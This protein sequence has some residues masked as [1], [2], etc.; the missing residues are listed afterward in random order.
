MEQSQE[1]LA[2]L[3]GWKDRLSEALCLALLEARGMQSVQ[4]H[5]QSPAAAGKMFHREGGGFVTAQTLP[6]ATEYSK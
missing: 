3:T 4:Q 5:Q 2:A 1:E 6:A